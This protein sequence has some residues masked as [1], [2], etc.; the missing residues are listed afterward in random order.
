MVSICQDQWGPKVSAFAVHFR[1]LILIP[2]ISRAG[3]VPESPEFF[4]LLEVL[5]QSPA[6]I[7][8]GF[9]GHAGNA[10]GSTSLSEA[11]EFLSKE[12]ESVN[13]AAK[14]A[15]EVISS[16]YPEAVVS[17]PFV[18]SVG[19]TP[20]AHA[21]NAETRKQLSELLYGVLDVS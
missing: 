9:Y 10:Y 4:A 12:V 5:L 16:S 1:L 17:K 19:S 20:T 7:L 11:S 13:I 14:S 21:A 15:L 2:E 18:L 3:V 8:H 6:T